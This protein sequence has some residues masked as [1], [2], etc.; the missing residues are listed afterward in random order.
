MK[1]NAMELRE[2]VMDNSLTLGRLDKET[3]G[4]EDYSELTTLYTNALD[5]LTAW[6]SADYRHTSTKKDEDGAYTAIKAI[7]ALFSTDEERIIIDKTSMRTMRDCATKPKRLYSKEYTIAEKARKAQA[8]TAAERY[9]DLLTLGCD[10]RDEDESVQEYSARINESG[11]NVIVDGIDMLSMY[12]NANA[13]LTVKTKAVEDIK[14]AGNWTWKRPIA[15]ALPEFADL[16]ENYIADCLTD[17]YNIKS[18]AT[19]RA[20]KAEARAMAKAE[21][22]AENTAA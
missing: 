9:A 21:K 2:M 18:S 3:L 8:K 7:L 15:V 6:A 1:K 17:G 20:E 14:A 11:V 16:V 19:V 4:K 12:V 13:V 5:S 10:E 22:A